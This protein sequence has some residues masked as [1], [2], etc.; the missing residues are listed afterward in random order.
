MPRDSGCPV[1]STTTNGRSHRGIAAERVT[2]SAYWRPVAA[3]IAAG[4]QGSWGPVVTRPAAPAAAAT[5]TDAPM[6]RRFL[7]FSNM[8]TGAGQGLTKISVKETNGRSAIEITPVGGVYR[9][10]LAEYGFGDDIMIGAYP[11][12]QVRR[13]F[14]CQLVQ[15]YGVDGN[16]VRYLR[17]ETKSV[18]QGMKPF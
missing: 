9:S 13:V 18:F 8:T 17:A 3:I 1:G 5:L 12:R 7:G 15:A 14:R 10:Q 16:D 4:F 2:G 6:L 11:M